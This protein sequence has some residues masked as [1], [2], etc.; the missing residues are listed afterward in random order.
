MSQS[1]ADK[2]RRSFMIATLELITAP[3]PIVFRPGIGI[4]EETRLLAQVLDAIASCYEVDGRY[5]RLVAR[6]CVPGLNQK[7]GFKLGQGME[8]N[9]DTVTFIENLRRIHEYV[10]V[11]RTEAV[12]V[13]ILIEE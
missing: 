10:R 8:E 11:Y 13:T 3:R 5:G 1:A 9:D 7:V 6:I 4:V 2:T 12:V